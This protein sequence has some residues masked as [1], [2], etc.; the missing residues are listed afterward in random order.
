[1]CPQAILGQHLGGVTHSPPLL[2]H[3]LLLRYF[4][5]PQIIVSTEMAPSD[6]VLPGLVT[7][8]FHWNDV[9]AKQGSYLPCSLIPSWWK[10]TSPQAPVCAQ[11]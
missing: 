7:C 5:H 4:L 10:K 11:W 8:A 9:V 1:M 6:T 2:P 3:F